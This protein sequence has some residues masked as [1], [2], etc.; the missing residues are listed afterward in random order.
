M[1]DLVFQNV[2]SIEN[3]V[4]IF[5]EFTTMQKF[6]EINLFL[7]NHIHKGRD[8]K[9]EKFTPTENYFVKPTSKFFSKFISLVKTLLSRKFCQK[10]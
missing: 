5:Q 9:N 3:T 10:V 7:Q 1:S 6:R 8:L 4:W 2:A